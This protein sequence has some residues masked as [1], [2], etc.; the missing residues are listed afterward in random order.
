MQILPS[1]TKSRIKQG[2]SG[3]QRMISSKFQLGRRFGSRRTGGTPCFRRHRLEAEYRDTDLLAG[4]RRL[5]R[6]HFDRRRYSPRQRFHRGHLRPRRLH[7]PHSARRSSRASL[8][9]RVSRCGPGRKGP[10][11]RFQIATNRECL[12]AHEKVCCFHVPAAHRRSNY[13]LD[14]LCNHSH[15]VAFGI[16]LPCCGQPASPSSGR[17]VVRPDL[18]PGDRTTAQ[19]LKQAKSEGIGW[20][21]HSLALELNSRGIFGAA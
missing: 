7:T 18:Q 17:G 15:F 4:Q 13:A 12:W 2:D 3:M 14:N 21:Q 10:G 1:Q 8:G 6:T 20:L 5:C 19:L 9:K 11:R 16:Q